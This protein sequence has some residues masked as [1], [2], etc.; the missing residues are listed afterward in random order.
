MKRGCGSTQGYVPYTTSLLRLIAQ[1]TRR[2]VSFRLSM[3]LNIVLWSG[4]GVGETP[5]IRIEVRI[6]VVH[7]RSAAHAMSGG[8]HIAYTE[9]LRITDIILVCIFS[10]S[11]LDQ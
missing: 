8:R 9:P 11:R 3:R 4:R 6:T 5:T 1:R 7:I 10:A 2:G